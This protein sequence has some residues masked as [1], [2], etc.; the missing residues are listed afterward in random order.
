MAEE[1]TLI[2][3]MQNRIRVVWIQAKTVCLGDSLLLVILQDRK[4]TEPLK[5]TVRKIKYWFA[6][7]LGILTMEYVLREI[8]I[9]TYSFLYRKS[10]S[11]GIFAGYSF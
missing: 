6:Y 4:V 10:S 3:W 7:E 11:S 5:L 1:W 9:S 8:C 2:G